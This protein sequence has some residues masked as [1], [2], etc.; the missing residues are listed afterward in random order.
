MMN[1]N[2]VNLIIFD[3]D[4][5]IVPSLP[6][7]YE[8]IKR[9]FAKLGWPVDF[10][11]EDINK[12]F[13]SPTDSS[14]GGLY[15]FIR[16]AGSHL[17]W[18]EVREKVREEYQ[19][20]FREL[21]ET[22][23]GVKE[24]LAAL[25]KRDYKLALYSNASTLYF[26]MVISALHIRDYFDYTECI[27]EKN[28]TKSELVQ[29]IK[30]K[31]NGLTA[32]VCGDRIHDIEASRETG[33]LSIGIL[34]GYGGKEPEQADITI[35]SFD[36]LLN[37]FDRKLPIFEKIS[38]E[39]DQRKPGNRPFVVG[40]TGIDS[41]GKTLF[42]ESL[43]KFLI[44]KNRKVQV[45]NLDDFHNPRQVRY[46]GRNQADN[47]YHRSFNIQN[48][49]ENL[50]IPARQK[51]EHSVTLTLLDLLTDKYEIK[52]EYSLKPETIILF[53]GVFL[54][55]KELA[56]YIDFKVFLE[57][58]FDESK[59]RAKTRDPEAVLNKY[60]RKYLPAQARYLKDYPPQEVA[61]MI[62][63]NMNWEYPYIRH[64]R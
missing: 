2:A 10:S 32:A 33:S 42:T 55:R 14:G 15:E 40:I 57:I 63:N 46:S 54:F 13:G 60:D 31:F 36:E 27:F 34:F 24:T 28:L 62:I 30:G 59:K 23:P 44:S 51:G 35:N 37:I 56:E 4:G 6:A 29:K 58:P 21:A 8:G 53:E 18:S 48:I 3:M 38:G 7:V 61:D 52:K 47:Y 49:I 5:T 25:R 50:M 16:P 9:A 45:I 12:F 19:D 39:I 11:A 64:L 43:A 17:T 22:Y 41:S 1:P 20:T 26:D